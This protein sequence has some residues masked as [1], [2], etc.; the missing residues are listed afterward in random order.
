MKP[1]PDL[2]KLLV[3]IVRFIIP[4]VL[5]YWLVKQVDWATVLPL[6][7]QTS[8]SMM[9]LSAG[10][11]FSSHL[12]FAVRWKYLLKIKNIVPTYLKLLG[13]IMISI[14]ASNFLPTTIGGDVV[15][16]VGLAKD[17]KDNK[18]IAAASVIAD[19]L[20][21]LAGMVLLFPAALLIISKPLGIFVN[22]GGSIIDV[23]GMAAST[24]INKIGLK[25]K[26]VWSAS[27]VWFTSPWCVIYSLGLSILSVGLN[28][29][30]FW[31]IL[32]GLGIHISYW[33]AM[34]VSIL[35]YFV[36]LIPL[37]INGLGIQEG[38]ITYLL[39]LLGAGTD[40]AVAAA[41]LIRIVTMAVSLIGG[42]WL[43]FGGKGLLT[44]ARQS[45]IEKTVLD[46]DKK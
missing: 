8:I 19:R 30:A 24:W 2:L 27:R 6:I 36:A 7:K 25:I 16:M 10:L 35:S 3:N 37:A 41:F 46:S 32:K 13:L 22:S 34:A 38:S 42:V 40:Q 39:V 9:L 21:N 15:K 23:S 11:F 45:E 31:V 20:Y 43:I 14:F 18:T 28:F 26:K 29:A 44:L 5:I 4:V 17:E 1:K 33:Q 12:L